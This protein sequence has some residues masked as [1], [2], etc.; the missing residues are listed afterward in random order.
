MSHLNY[1][2]VT[3][4]A[5]DLFNLGNLNLSLVNKFISDL[6]VCDWS[7]F[8]CAPSLSYI[9]HRNVTYLLSCKLTK[10]DVRVSR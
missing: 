2:A 4:N 5:G 8:V 10:W 6:E 1:A 3:P 7:T 9:Q